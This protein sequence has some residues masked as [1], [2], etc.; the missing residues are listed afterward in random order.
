MKGDIEKNMDVLVG[1]VSLHSSD[2][3]SRIDKDTVYSS[4][5]ASSDKQRSEQRDDSWFRWTRLNVF[6]SYSKTQVCVVDVQVYFQTRHDIFSCLSFH[7]WHESGSE[8][9][10]G[11]CMAANFLSDESVPT[12]AIRKE[13]NDVLSILVWRPQAWKSTVWLTQCSFRHYFTFSQ[14]ILTSVFG[15]QDASSTENN[16]SRVVTTSHH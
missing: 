5:T 15:L 13:T 12:G 1:S 11:K 16:A 9:R 3:L 6:L 7:V 10:D 4:L 2:S 8:T 14:G